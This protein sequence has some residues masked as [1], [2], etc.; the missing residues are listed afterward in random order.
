ML[1]NPMNFDYNIVDV[2]KGFISICKKERKVKIRIVLMI[3]I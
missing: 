1:V 3:M 2:M